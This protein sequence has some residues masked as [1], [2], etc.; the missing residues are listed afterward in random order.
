MAAI[1]YLQFQSLGSQHAQVV[2]TVVGLPVTL[3]WQYTEEC[4]Y[5]Q[6]ITV[7]H[8][9]SDYSHGT[10][11]M[12]GSDRPRSERLV[13]RTVCVRDHRARSSAQNIN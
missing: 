3:P 11:H 12:V 1:K 10:K 4:S 2:R 13:I 9:K 8:Y 7:C 5:Q 6:C